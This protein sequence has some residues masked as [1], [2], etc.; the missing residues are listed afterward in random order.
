MPGKMDSICAAP[1][2]LVCGAGQRDTNCIFHIL[3]NASC[4][5]LTCKTEERKQQLDSKQLKGRKTSC[6]ISNQYFQMKHPALLDISDV[7]SHCLS[8]PSPWEVT[9]PHHFS[10]FAPYINYLAF[11]NHS[12]TA[13]MNALKNL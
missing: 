5:V 8:P 12:N 6:L 11:T 4:G 2:G 7:I 10:R 13:V 3:H 1:T 9:I